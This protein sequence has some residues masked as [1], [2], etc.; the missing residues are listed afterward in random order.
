MYYLLIDSGGMY[1]GVQNNETLQMNAS[2]VSVLP[3]RLYF[4]VDLV[5]D[6]GGARQARVFKQ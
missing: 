5:S 6:V 4:L 2:I 1:F 3:N